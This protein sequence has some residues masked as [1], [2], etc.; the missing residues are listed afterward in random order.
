[1]PSDIVRDVEVEKM[2]MSS[3]P[4]ISG[5]NDTYKKDVM[6]FMKFEVDLGILKKPI[7]EIKFFGKVVNQLPII[8]FL[9]NL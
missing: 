1:M 3:F 9:H 5:L 6:D 2:S 4:F 8:F 7:S